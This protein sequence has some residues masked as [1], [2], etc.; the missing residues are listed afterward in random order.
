MKNKFEL[1][2]LVFGGCKMHYL[3]DI[4]WCIIYKEA[5]GIKMGLGG[6]HGV[7]RLHQSFHHFNGGHM[8]AIYSI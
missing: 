6:P 4:V 2:C 7:M 5:F 8:N 3:E 1:F